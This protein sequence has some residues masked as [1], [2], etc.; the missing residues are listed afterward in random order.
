MLK[1]SSLGLKAHGAADIPGLFCC[2]RAGVSSKEA[3][4]KQEQGPGAVVLAQ[5]NCLDKW[6][7]KFSG[8]KDAAG[9]CT[10]YTLPGREF[11]WCLSSAVAF[12]RAVGAMAST[13]AL[14]QGRPLG[15]ALS[16]QCGN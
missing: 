8:W 1:T 9:Q 2:C 15:L 14:L 16:G 7:E 13:T 3:A 10:G 11:L 12:P 5:G 6:L 4:D